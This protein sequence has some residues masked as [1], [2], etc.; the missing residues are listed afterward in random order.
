MSNNIRQIADSKVTGSVTTIETII[1]VRWQWISLPLLVV[2]LGTHFVLI[3]AWTNTGIPVWKEGQLPTLFH[4]L[5]TD[6]RRRTASQ[7]S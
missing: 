4:G 5:E 1:V 6:T 3:T 7:C 2:V